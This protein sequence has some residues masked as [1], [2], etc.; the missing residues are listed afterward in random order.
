MCLEGMFDSLFVQVCPGSSR[1]GTQ[2]TKLPLWWRWQFLLGMN[3]SCL[4]NCL[5][6]R[7]QQS[8]WCKTSFQE[9]G[10]MSPE[11]NQC[12][13]L[14]YRSAD[15]DQ[16]GTR[17]KLLDPTNRCTCRRGSFDTKMRL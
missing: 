17:D 9:R 4:K 16:M 6:Q 12:R 15:I 7:N 2:H 1:L 5:K 3:R 14:R 10:C 13:Y 11:N 8:S